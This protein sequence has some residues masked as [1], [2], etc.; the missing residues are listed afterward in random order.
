M[1]LRRI[2]A[3]TLLAAGLSACGTA[4]L[5]S[6]NASPE[7]SSFEGPVYTAKTS[8]YNIVDLRVNVPRDLVVSEANLFYP[9]GDIVWRAEPYGDRHEQVAAIFRDGLGRGVAKLNVGPEAILDVKVHRF[10][11]LSEKARHSTGGVHNMV[12]DLTVLDAAT[13]AVLQPTAR[14]QIDLDAYGGRRAFKAE[15]MGQTQRVRVTDELS[16]YIVA[17]MT[18]P[19]SGP[20]AEAAVARRVNGL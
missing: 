6:R 9:G 3:L 19:V 13:G 20:V 17:T 12:F 2:A 10:H 14:H 1:K 11:S 5:A 8:L 18:T 16:R 15:R 4:D 7:A